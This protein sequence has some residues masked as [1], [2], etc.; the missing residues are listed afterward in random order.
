MKKEHKIIIKNISLQILEML[1]FG[2]IAGRVLSTAEEV[3]ESREEQEKKEMEIQREQSEQEYQE[4]LDQIKKEKTDLLRVL[5]PRKNG[6]FRTLDICFNRSLERDEYIQ[7][8][9]RFKSSGCDIPI[10]ENDDDGAEIHDAY[11]GVTLYLDEPLTE[12]EAI[13]VLAKMQLL[14]QDIASDLEVDF[15]E[16]LE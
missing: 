5:E 12:K 6:S 14:L 8:N 16:S 1:P 11:D 10:G 3:R 7:F 4:R 2:S 13:T 15:E 9:K